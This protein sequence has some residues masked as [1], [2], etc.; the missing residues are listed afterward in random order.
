YDA[1]AA[2]PAVQRGLK[3]LADRRKPLVDD[4]A[5]ETLFGSTQYGRH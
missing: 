3:V 2:R 5:R 1:V 4:K